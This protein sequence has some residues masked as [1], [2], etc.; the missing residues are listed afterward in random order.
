MKRQTT[1]WEN[2]FVNDISDKGLISKMYKEHIK[3]NTKKINNP[4]K[5]C[6][7]ELNRHFPKRIHKWPKDM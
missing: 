1:E 5:Y 3:L 6:A 4:I 2:I 7:K